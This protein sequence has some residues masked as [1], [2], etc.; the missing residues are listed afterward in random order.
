MGFELKFKIKLVLKNIISTKIHFRRASGN[1]WPDSLAFVMD[2]LKN[3]R[4]IHI[5]M[6]NSS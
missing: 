6:E 1:V 2:S 3:E 5:V 4:L